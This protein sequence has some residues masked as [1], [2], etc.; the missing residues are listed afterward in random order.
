M[1]DKNFSHEHV[2]RDCKMPLDT[3]CQADGNGGTFIIVT[4]WNPQCL[5]RAVT[6]SLNTYS[7]LSDSDWEAYREMNRTLAAKPE[8]Y[9][10]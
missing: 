6:R 5:L 8:W 7:T 1:A 9:G 3:Q 10:V 4:C 2:C